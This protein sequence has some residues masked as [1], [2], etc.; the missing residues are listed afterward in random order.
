MRFFF[1]L[2]FL[3]FAITISSG[4]QNKI[5][6]GIVVDDET[7][8]KVPF[9][10]ISVFKKSKLVNGTSTNESGQFRLKLKEAITR[11]E[12]SFIGYETTIL[13]LENIKNSKL[14]TFVLKPLV[15][16]LDEVVI[17][18]AQSTTQ[19]KIDRKVINLGA[20]LQQSGVTALEAFDQITEIQTDL[21]TGTLSLRGSGNVR[22]LVNGKPSG[23]SATELLD[24]LPAASVSKIEIITTPSAKKQANGLS[25]IINIILKKNTSKGLNANINSGFGTKRYSYGL[26]GNYNFSKVNFRWNLS[27]AGRAMDSKQNISQLYNNG[28]TRDFFA[29]HDFNGLIRTLN[30]GLDFYI[31]ENNELSLAFDYTN[32]EHSFYNNTF[33]SNVTNREDYIYTRNSS[34]THK[35]T[36]LNIN[37]R[38]K[39]EGDN[40]FLE[41]DY[42]FSNNNNLLPAEDFEEGIFLFEEERENKNKLNAL[43]IDYSFS[44]NDIIKFESGFSWNGRKLNSRNLF[45]FAQEEEMLDVFKYNESLFGIYALSNIKLGKLNVQFGVRYENLKSDSKNFTT[46]KTT[47]LVFSNFFPSLHGSYKINKAQALSLG[48]SRRVSRPNFRHIN[49]FQARNQYFEW[50]SNPNLKPEFSNNLEANYQYN[51]NKLNFSTSF[52]YRYRTAVIERLQEIDTDGVQSNFFDNIGEKHSYGLEATISY[53]LMS[54]WNNELSANY[55]HTSVNQDVFLV[56][57]ELYSSN[58]IFKNTFKINKKFSADI[59]YRYNFKTQ[60]TFSFVEPRN[61]ID[62]AMRLKLLENRLSMNLRVVDVLDNNLMLRKIVTQNVKQDEVWRFQTQ[63]FGFLFSVNYKLFQNKVK[64]RNRKDRDYQYGG[65]TD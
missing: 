27:Q 33:Y 58:T 65:T 14:I 62:I 17:Q 1:T 18:A 52:F 51:R 44:I 45:N 42:Q 40:H 2:F 19:L 63:T 53:K 46:D 32:N 11:F 12:V 7:K 50:L 60:N 10:T 43:S 30:T 31:N 24:Q 37:Y 49:P 23:L 59:T 39:F 6:K 47:H 41:F 57:D 22:L 8:E 35:T 54:F 9:A 21:G 64:K 5:Y 15:S 20:D 28:D 36:N 48:Y 34:H 25:G 16:L 61:R 26:D 3:L 13:N 56:W 29:P 38:A 4:Q 55:Y